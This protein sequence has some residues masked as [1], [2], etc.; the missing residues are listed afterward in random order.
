MIPEFYSRDEHG[1]PRAWVARMRESMA[2]LTPAFSTDRVVRQYTDEYYLP[3]AEGFRRRAEKQ[4]SLEQICSIGDRSGKH[5]RLLRFGSGDSRTE[6]EQFLPVQ[7]FLDD[8]DPDA[9]K[10]SSMRK[11]LI[12]CT[13][14]AADDPGGTPRW[15]HQR[16]YVH[17]AI[18]ANRPAATTRRDLFPR[19]PERTSRWRVPSSCGTTR[20]CGDEPGAEIELED[21]WH[22]FDPGPLHPSF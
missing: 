16:L 12:R 9:V 4:G 22:P 10:R 21:R 5:W 18:P 11:A 1:I 19:I 6:A 3:A 2:R 7:V 13:C 14:H 15:L 8:L 17:G 20:L